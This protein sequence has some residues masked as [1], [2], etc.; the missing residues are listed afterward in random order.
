AVARPRSTSWSGFSASTSEGDI[1]Q[2]PLTN[3]DRSTDRLELHP[4]T[5]VVVARRTHV[6]EPSGTDRQQIC[7]TESLGIIENGDEFW[8]GAHHRR[9]TRLRWI[10]LAK[11]GM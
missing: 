2:R 8:I 7:V 11:A 9:M 4:E 5:P 1:S 10:E 3:Q 6:G